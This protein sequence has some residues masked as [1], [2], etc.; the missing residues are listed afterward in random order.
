M[1]SLATLSNSQELDSGVGRTDESTKN[2]ESSEHDILQGD[3]QTSAS[4]TNATNTPGS[5][6]KFRPGRSGG[7]GSDTPSPLFPLRE[8][9]LSTDSLECGSVGG[10]YLQNPVS[11][12]IMPG[13]TEE[14]CDRYRKLLEIKCRYEKRMK[15][16]QKVQEEEQ[17]EGETQEEAENREETLDENSN[18]NLTPHEMALLEEEMRHLDFKCRNILRAQKMQQLRERCLKA[19]LMEEETSG[20]VSAE[21]QGSPLHELSDINELPEKERSDKDSTSAYNTGGESCRS[22]PMASEHRLPV[23]QI[24]ESTSPLPSRHRDRATWSE[25]GRASLTSLYSPSSYKFQTNTPMNQKFCSL[26]REGT[27][28]RKPDGVA[29]GGNSRVSSHNRNGGRSAESSPY[30]HSTPSFQLLHSRTLPELHASG[31]L[32]F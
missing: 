16:V 12:L 25:R 1:L 3:E 18:E 15:K 31:I 22:T 13:L 7:G 11:G 6:R 24:D 21:P 2:E 5:L 10:G 27:V 20:R 26:T 14:E 29:L 9:H 19:W 30:F 8:L 23:S 28:C 32:T 4:N 17:K